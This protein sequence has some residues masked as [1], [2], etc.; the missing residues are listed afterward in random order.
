MWCCLGSQCF[1][2]TEKFLE[3][4]EF[5]ALLPQPQGEK[6]T[7]IIPR[8]N[9]R[10]GLPWCRRG[11]TE[12]TPGWGRSGRAT[13]QQSLHKLY[14]ISNTSSKMRT[15]TRAWGPNAGYLQ[16]LLICM[17]P[18]RGQQATGSELQ[19]GG[20]AVQDIP[21]R[22]CIQTWNAPRRCTKTAALAAR[23]QYAAY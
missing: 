5:H 4:S 2:Q 14:T 19:S 12:S 21:Y 23:T 11:H 10:A 22:G 20:S 9:R 8:K 18:W 17:C 7:C 13:D 6:L 16:A 3:T 15:Y 1:G